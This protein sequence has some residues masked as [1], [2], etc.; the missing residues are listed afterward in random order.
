[1]EYLIAVIV[2][3]VFGKLYTEYKILQ[4]IKKTAKESGLDLD[5]EM[6]KIREKEEH[7]KVRKLVV[8]K[9]GSVLYLF[10]K[11]S[12]EF[13]CQANTIDELA[14]LAKK[15]KNILGAVVLHDKKV[16]MFM[17]GLSKEYI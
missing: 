6:A 7:P 12:D 9:H 17:D 14:D 1:M 13:V 10:D 3:F 15:Y 16:F 2:G 4:Q 5:K 11:E 8:E